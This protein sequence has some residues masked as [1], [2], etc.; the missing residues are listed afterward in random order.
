M[1]YFHLGKISGAVS[2][3]NAC[4]TNET[5][6]YCGKNS[7]GVN[8]MLYKMKGVHSMRDTI[9]LCL[10]YPPLQLIRSSKSSQGNRLDKA[11]VWLL[12][13]NM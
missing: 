6:Y 8:F 3:K 2:V 4:M 13:S 12:P 9:P 10:Y 1:K 5:H 11:N 7:P